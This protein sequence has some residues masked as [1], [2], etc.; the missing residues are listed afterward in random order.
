[1]KGKIERVND[2]TITIT[3]LPLKK[4]TQSY[5]EFLE[6]MLTGDPKTQTPPE[7]K[8]LK[9]NH[10]ETTVSFTI[11]AEKSKI[12]EFEKEQK[13][14]YGKF[15]L[16]GSLATSN[17]TLH[18]AEHRIIKYTTPEDILNAFYDVRLEFYSK[19]KA[20]LICRLEAEKKTL[21]NKARFVEEVCAGDLVVSNRK[22]KDILDDLQERGYDLII[23]DPKKAD[24]SDGD[25]SKE[26]EDDEADDEPTTAELAKGY[27]YLLG[28]K[29]WSLTYEKAEQ[30][31]AELEEKTRD[32]EILQATDPSEIWLHDLDAIENAI[33]ERDQAIN[34]AAAEEQRAR[35]K[36]Q[37]RQAKASKKKGGR[38]KKKDEWDSEMESS[39]EDKMD[40][41]SED[42]V[43]VVQKKPAAR[44]KPRAAPK[45][46]AKKAPAVKSVSAPAA[47]SVLAGSPPPPKKAASSESESDDDF[48]ISL[49]DRLKKK[50]I[51]SPLAKKRDSSGSKDSKKRPSPKNVDSDEPESDDDFDFMETDKPKTVKAKRSAVATKKA[52]VRKPKAAAKKPVARKKVASFDDTDSEDFEFHSSSSSDEFA[53]VGAPARART[54]RRTAVK[55][56]FSSDEDDESDEY[57]EEE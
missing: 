7:I 29:I 57:D 3:E 48:G 50:L 21:S 19:R 49:S 14:L 37:K 55:Y 44:S 41:D 11:I 43:F 47:P 51:V 9:E 34:A 23:K 35:K 53:A 20:N 32:L 30:L 22:R 31:R 52:P 26:D 17:M 1:M 18:N 8:D 33:H 54:A 15:K 10:T 12:D 46:V 40:T 39:E 56:S 25:D 36:S 6:P 45:P 4:W 5:K 13:G 24:Q 28:M 27:E 42:E 16:T 2:T 38:K